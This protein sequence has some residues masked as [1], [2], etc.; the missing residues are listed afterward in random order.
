MNISKVKFIYSLLLV[1][2]VMA[3]CQKQQEVK[4]VQTPQAHEV[5]QALENLTYHYQGKTYDANTWN[6]K[7]ADVKADYPVQIND[8][9][10]MF[11]DQQASE[12]FVAEQLKP[13][14][15]RDP[16]ILEYGWGFRITFYEHVD[17]GGKKWDYIVRG[18][19]EDRRSL[20]RNMGNFW[21]GRIS[22]LIIHHEDFNWLQYGKIHFDFYKGY[23]ARGHLFGKDAFFDRHFSEDIKDANIGSHNDKIHS[24]KVRAS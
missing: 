21:S 1:V 13:N 19:S 12:Q 22:S 18:R 14:N 4:P 23:N 20:V 8:D 17:Y 3:S 7:F 16:R 15:K 5:S 2:L 9:V 6:A 11:Q 24:L 10:Y